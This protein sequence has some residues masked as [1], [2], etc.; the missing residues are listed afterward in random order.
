MNCCSLTRV[1]SANAL[2]RNAIPKRDPV[3]GCH[4]IALAQATCA[5]NPSN[6]AM[7]R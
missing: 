6:C 5:S 1:G 3:D 2:S 4:Y 7:S